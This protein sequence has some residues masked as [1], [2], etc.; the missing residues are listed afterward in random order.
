MNKIICITSLAFV[1]LLTA[2]SLWKDDISRG[3]V[4]DKKARFIGDILN[5]RVQESN[6][7]KREG[8]TSTSRS[9]STDA[10]I[11][12]LFF[13]TSSATDGSQA[14]HH[15]GAFP[16]MK[17][18]NATKHDGSGSID[19]SDSLTTRFA[20]R[21]ADVMPN[22]NLLVEGIR[23]TSFGGEHQTIILRG[24][25]RADD[26]AADNSVYSYQ[27]ADMHIRYLS[28]GVVS[29]TADKGWFMKF[30]DKI[31]PF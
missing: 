25:V 2:D 13:T 31:S 17:F 1:G 28:E 12:N 24:T 18:E 19:N 26:I 6:S 11:S 14:F 9:S 23:K 21:V 30:W 16:A 10:S 4:S 3:P 29:N 22:R 15:N 5:I 8:K 27:I 20:V 7:A